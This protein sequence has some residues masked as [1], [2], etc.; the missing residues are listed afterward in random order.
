ML[1]PYTNMNNTRLFVSNIPRNIQNENLRTHFAAVG[2]VRDVYIPQDKMTG[3]P[4]GIAFV[5]MSSVDEANRAL[6]TLNKKQ[7]LGRTI[8]VAVAK[9]RENEPARR[10]TTAPRGRNTRSNGKN[11]RTEILD[12]ASF[13]EKASVII[14]EKPFTPKQTYAQFALDERLK[15]N[16]ATIGY[17]LP[18]PIQDEGIPVILEGKDIVGIANTGTG[19][20]AAFLIPLINKLIN[21][22][23][24]K[25]L[26]LTPTRELAAQINEELVKFARGL[27]IYGT[28]CIGG[29]NIQQQ[30]LRLRRNPNFV[31]GTPGR[32]K[33]LSNTRHLHLNEFQNIV[34]DEADRMME[35]G[36]IDD[37]KD[38]I[39]RLPQ[40]RQ[41]LFFS[42]TLPSSLKPLMNTF[43][44]DP[45]TIS[46]KVQE[47]SKNIAQ[48]VVYVGER[49]KLEVL[50]ELLYQKDLSKVLVFVRTKHGADK[51]LKELIKRGF[52][53]DAIH[54]NKTQARRLSV[55]KKF[56]EDK[57]K[58]LVATDVAARGLDIS[59]ISH[60]INYDIPQTY[61][62]YIHR[63]GRTGRYDKQGFAL[64]LI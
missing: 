60:V 63:I 1:L 24:Q 42:A 26:I 55:L 3:Q 22:R 37:M 44:K 47:T 19:K 7:L 53:A 11:F 4:K 64:T 28:L 21:D 50:C 61:E 31:I 45:V 6:E 38:I 14:E 36:F 62:E 46:L 52:S 43:L 16:I 40:P 27:E 30:I 59:N 13:I 58:I 23:R 35:M 41:S 10:I 29:A 17:T 54:G 51:I 15:R 49:N 48:D 5:E 33:D 56:K 57:I 34:L 32:I 12:I 20:T 39:S 18:T 8:F 2:T 25:V 9:E